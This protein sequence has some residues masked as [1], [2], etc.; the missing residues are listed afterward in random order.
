MI[1]PKCFPNERLSE[2]AEAEVFTRLQALAQDHD[3]FYSKRFVTDGIRKKPEFEIDFIIIKPSRAIICLEV[4]GGLLTYDGRQDEWTQNG[5]KL[6]KRPDVQARDNAFSFIK[7]YPAIEKL[8]VIWG[9]CFPNTPLDPN[10]QLPSFIH[11][12]Q[13]IDSFKLSY[14]NQSLDELFKLAIEQHAYRTGLAKKEYRKFVHT[15]SESINEPDEGTVI[16]YGQNKIIRLT[17]EQIEQFQRV[18]TNTRIITTGPAGSGKTLLAAH[19][20]N[21]LKDKGRSV[22]T[23]CYNRSVANWA[24]YELKADFTTFHSFAKRTIENEFPDWL[25]SKEKDQEFWE[26][27]IPVK[28]S[29]CSL[30]GKQPY[31]ALIIDEGQDFK[32][33]W[34]EIL[35]KFVKDK[36]CIYIFKDDNQDIFGRSPEIPYRERFM[37][38]SLSHN[39]RN[40][41][42]IVQYLDSL[43]AE[44]IFSFP[45]SPDGFPV[46][47]KTFKDQ[48]EEAAF[49]SKEIVRL[50]H[51]EQVRP[52]QILIILNTDKKESC[53]NELKKIG[54]YK[55]ESSP[56]GKRPRRDSIHYTTIKMFK[57]LETDIAFIVDVPVKNN[58]GTYQENILRYT[59]IS[60]ARHKCYLLTFS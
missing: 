60:R 4:K 18:E 35:F 6:A 1:Y 34:Y 3:I 43:I 53:L 27:E 46:I 40:S 22:L 58:E 29:E 39:Y 54:R 41:K 25:S 55:I 15:L 33:L 2:K 37:H 50:I 48:K 24:R 31:D 56:L 59:Q 7:Q 45:E 10:G 23:L 11:P 57:G 19:A 21:T 17:R 32:D 51:E 12:A 20:S 52:E 38:Y 42:Q 14:L 16:E 36:G 5:T 49:L 9:L 8:P 26:L 30:A 47:E 44:D 28:L 13:L